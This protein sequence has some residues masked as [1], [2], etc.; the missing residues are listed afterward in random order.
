MHSIMHF[1][2]MEVISRV[3]NIYF[4]GIVHTNKLVEVMHYRPKIVN[5]GADIRFINRTSFH[6]FARI[7]YVFIRFFFVMIIFYLMPFMIIYLQWII[8]S[9]KVEH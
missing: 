1:V 7:I 9:I 5:K 3:S 6:K 2:A 4:E 8:K